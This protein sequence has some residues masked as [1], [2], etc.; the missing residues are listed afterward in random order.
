VTLKYR[1]LL[2]FGFAGVLSAQPIS[3][4]QA[5]ESSLR[6]YPSIRVSQEQ[7]NAAAAGIQLARTAYLPKVDALAQ[8][9]RATRNNVFGLLLPQN[10]IPSISGPVI[11]SNNLGSVWGSALGG[12]V[13]WEPFDFGL[14]AAGVALATSAR[15]QSA[16]AARRTEFDV[17]VAAADAYVTVVAAQETV[18]AAQA[19]VDRAETLLKAITAQVNAELR[20]GADRSRAEAELAAARTQVIQAQQAVDISRATL[21]QFVGSDPA[22]IA[23]VPGSLVELPPEQ[24]PQSFE[25]AANPAMV[26]QNAAVGQAHAQL[27]VLERTYFPKFYLQGSAYARGTGADV[28]GSRLGG[29]NGL[30]PTVQNFAV[31]LTVTFPVLDLPALRAR[32][33][34]QSATIRSQTARSEQLAVEL[35][36]QWNR[37]VAMLNGSRRIAANT[38]VQVEAARAAVQQANARYEAGLANIAEA[39]DAQRL[40]TQAEIDNVLARLGVWRGLLGIATAAG[41]LQPFIAEASR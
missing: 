17:A 14:R 3:L 16:A 32:E 23:V 35:R 41:D 9:N 34:A 13:T 25:A 29:V 38:P 33:A 31:G 20:P 1:V 4:A 6:N 40:L 22:Q 36:A 30:G 37:A 24:A 18:R 26:E 10:V 5:V 7:I 19:G 15:E 27:K 2:V 39:A 8:V 21:A 11:G 28:N 12:L